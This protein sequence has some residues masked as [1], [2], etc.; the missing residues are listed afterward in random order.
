MISYGKTA[1]ATDKPLARP[2]L[3]SCYKRH[4]QID[5]TIMEHKQS[6]SQNGWIHA[7]GTLAT[8]LLADLCESGNE[9]VR[10]DLQITVIERR[11]WLSRGSGLLTVV[12]KE[13]TKKRF[14]LERIAYI[15]Y[16]EGKVKAPTL[17]PTHR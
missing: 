3:S 13:G 15:L 10:L 17:R 2:V 14:I 8:G 16:R 5:F 1:A 7:T 12:L 11:E 9:V 4:K 6:D